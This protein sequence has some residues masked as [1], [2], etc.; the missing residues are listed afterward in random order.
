MNSPTPQHIVLKDGSAIEHEVECDI[1]AYDDLNRDSDTRPSIIALPLRDSFASLSQLARKARGSRTTAV[2]ELSIAASVNEKPQSGQT[3]ANRDL[4]KARKRDEHEISR[5][6]II[7]AA[8]LKKLRSY[9]S[10]SSSRTLFRAITDRLATTQSNTFRNLTEIE[11]EGE[12]RQLATDESKKL[13][14]DYSSQADASV[15]AVL[16]ASY[17][18]VSS[19]P[20]TLQN[21]IGAI[22]RDVFSTN[23]IL[24]SAKHV[25]H[26]VS[27]FLKAYSKAPINNYDEFYGA[28]MI[29]SFISICAVREEACSQNDSKPLCGLEQLLLVARGQARASEK[30]WSQILPIL[31]ISLCSGLGWT[32]R[33]SSCIAL[34]PPSRSTRDVSVVPDSLSDGPVGWYLVGS[35]TVL[36]S[37]PGLQPTTYP[38]Y[39]P[40]SRQTHSSLKALSLQNLPVIGGDGTSGGRVC[41]ESVSDVLTLLSVVETEVSGSFEEYFHSPLPSR[42]QK[43]EVVSSK[44]P[45]LRFNTTTVDKSAHDDISSSQVQRELRL[46]SLKARE[47]FYLFHAIFSQKLSFSLK[48]EDSK[49]VRISSELSCPA[50]CFV[51]SKIA[52]CILS[53]TLLRSLDEGDAQNAPNLDYVPLLPGSILSFL[54]EISLSIALSC[55]VN[56]SLHRDEALDKLCLLLVKHLHQSTGSSSNKLFCGCDY[57]RPSGDTAS[58]CPNCGLLCLH[59]VT[60]ILHQ[61]QIATQTLSPTRETTPN[62]DVERT[63]RDISVPADDLCRRSTEYFSSIVPRMVSYV[64][65]PDK[66]KSKIISFSAIETLSTTI[67]KMCLNFLRS[68]QEIPLLTLTTVISHR[69]S[70]ESCLV[71]TGLS[72]P[73]LASSSQLQKSDSGST[74]NN[75][76]RD[77]ALEEIYDTVC[78]S[79]TFINPTSSEDGTVG[80]KCTLCEAD[81]VF[82][83]SIPSKETSFSVNALPNAFGK[84]EKIIS[85]SNSTSG[86]FSQSPLWVEIL[87]TPAPSPLISKVEPFWLCVDL[88]TGACFP[89]RIPVDHSYLHTS[90]LDQGLFCIPKTNTHS[91]TRK[92]GSNFK[93]TDLCRYV[94]TIQ[95]APRLADQEPRI[96]GVIHGDLT[97]PEIF[98]NL[99]GR[100][101]FARTYFDALQAFF[102]FSFTLMGASL[103]FIFHT[104]FDHLYLL[105]DKQAFFLFF[106][107]LVSLTLLVKK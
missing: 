8:W 60:S 46:M 1:L 40:C 31:F 68:V 49:Q 76:H 97:Y 36:S 74:K 82:L 89:H 15:I 24:P 94:T 21:E 105:I 93:S 48:N 86:S 14:S 33:L 104:R 101:I 27:D 75:G 81:L 92:K 4:T 43:C 30:A 107:D 87:C 67:Q 18:G 73:S 39:C 85:L 91:S 17:T 7:Y 63:M 90:S 11:V 6:R 16:G 103:N 38:E 42:E 100:K 106:G 57:T 69:I 95:L 54:P 99:T 72:P 53:D 2:S 32:T 45:S 77:D 88:E 78:P 84:E 23:R 22:C 83:G 65:F 70:S 62:K 19:D 80:S 66:V 71:V 58:P 47:N 29:S 26:L 44:E 50:V 34:T 102:F 9:A 55:P 3:K 20:T 56:P 79:C 98:P 25:S 41:A 52:A 12:M 59:A 28:N 5:Y 37:H 96:A 35:G 13:V 64:A 61:L 10:L 51:F